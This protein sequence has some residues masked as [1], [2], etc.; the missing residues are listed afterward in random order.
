MIIKYVFIEPKNVWEKRGFANNLWLS[1]D[2][3]K[4][5]YSLAITPYAD[6]NGIGVIEVK[7][8]SDIFKLIGE[9]GKNNKDT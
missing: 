9:L 2:H 6:T 5:T 1:V 7:R 4:N 8:K 3:E